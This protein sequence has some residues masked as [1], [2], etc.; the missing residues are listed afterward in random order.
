MRETN[1]NNMNQIKELAE[2]FLDGAVRFFILSGT[3]N[4]ESVNLLNHKLATE[5]VDFYKSAEKAGAALDLTSKTI[6]KHRRSP[7]RTTNKA[8]LDVAYKMVDEMPI[9]GFTKEQFDIKLAKRYAEITGKELSKDQ[10]VAGHVL[11]VLETLG[12]VKFTGRMYVPLETDKSERFTKLPDV[13]KS[14]IRGLNIFVESIYLKITQMGITRLPES[15]ALHAIV[16]ATIR[17]D[18][19]PKFKENVATNTLIL[20]ETFEKEAKKDL[21]NSIWYEIQISGL[22]RYCKPSEL[23]EE[24]KIKRLTKSAK[25]V[26]GGEK[27]ERTEP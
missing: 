8:V 12:R 19:I 24:F 15:Q 5:S 16:G 18:D 20:A 7:R 9:F 17:G 23:G 26:K 3:S 10:D 25:R 11:G 13:L 21:E 22:P 1:H 6:R 14:A 27:H 4:K 2:V